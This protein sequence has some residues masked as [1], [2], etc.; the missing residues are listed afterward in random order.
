MNNGTVAPARTFTDADNVWGNGTN[1]SGQSAA[2]D[3]HFGAAMTFDYYKNVH[4]RNGIFGNGAGVPTRVHF[5]SSYVNAFWDGAQMTYG[6]GASNAQPADRAR[7]G[8]PRDEPRRHRGAR[9]AA[10]STPASPAAS[11][12]RPATSSAP[13]SSSTPTTPAT[14]A[15]T[16]SARRSTS[17][18]T[19]R[20]CATCTTRRSTVPRTPAGPPATEERQ[21]ALLVRRRATTSSSC[22][23]RAPAP[24]RTAPRPVCGSAPAVTGIGRAKAEK[25]WYRALDVYFTSNTSYVNTTTPSNTARAYTLRAATDLYGLCSTAVQGRP[26]GVDRGQRGRQRRGLRRPNDFSSRSRRPRRRDGQP[27]HR[28]DRLDRARHRLRPDDRV[29]RVGPAQRRDRVVQPDLGH[30]R[31]LVDPDASHVRLDPGRHLP[32]HHHGHRH[33]RDAHHHVHADG[34]RRSRAARAPTRPT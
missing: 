1:S 29:L 31:R 34:Q 26:G 6:D 3:A 21:R 19:A 33:R 13:W 24:P 11:T 28:R 17:T 18:A 32:G 25:I 30:H 15:T 12:R 8:R 20:R 9:R 5:G 14:P 7:R 10:W 2:V 16:S 23:P 4:G 27:G 22:S